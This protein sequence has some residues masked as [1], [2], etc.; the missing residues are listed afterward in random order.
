MSMT[1]GQTLIGNYNFPDNT[2]CRPTSV[3]VRNYEIKHALTPYPIPMIPHITILPHTPYSV[4]RT[5]YP[6]LH[7]PQN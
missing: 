5:P 3:S 7:R 4:P 1:Y 6:I 2:N